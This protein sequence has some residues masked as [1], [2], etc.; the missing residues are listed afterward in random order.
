MT[1][2]DDMFDY[3]KRQLAKCDMK[4]KRRKT[5]KKYLE[6]GVIKECMVWLN[7]KGWY[8][9]RRNTGAIKMENT[10]LRFGRTGAADIFAVIH[11]QHVEIECKRRD[12][13][14]RL[15]DNQKEFQRE[16]ADYHIPYFV[17]T[18]ADDLEQ[19]IGT[20]RLRQTR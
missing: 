6:A 15:S 8:C 13:K 16:M 4:P 18:S 9:E 10:F 5:P 3:E 7:H 14:G 1:N 17:V 2:L 19:Q 20:L 11:G 12:G